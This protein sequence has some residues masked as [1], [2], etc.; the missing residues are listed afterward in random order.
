MEPI[1][2]RKVG[3]AV[4]KVYEDLTDINTSL[5]LPSGL[6]IAT[7]EDDTTET[8][9]SYEV[10]GEIDIQFKGDWYEDPTEYPDEL[11]EMLKNGAAGN[12]DIVV[13]ENNWFEGMFWSDKGWCGTCFCSDVVDIEGMSPEQ[14]ADDIQEWA[15]A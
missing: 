7:Y 15:K 1:Y 8:Y 9:L 10:Q 6:M 13:I 12:E 5:L 14:M 11:V 2:T 3:N 4:I